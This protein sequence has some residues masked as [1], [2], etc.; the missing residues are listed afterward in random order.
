[1]YRHRGSIARQSRERQRGAK[2]RSA[3][4]QVLHTAVLHDALSR[5][6]A[7][8]VRAGRW[9]RRRYPLQIVLDGLQVPLAVLRSGFPVEWRCAEC[10]Q[11][12][13]QSQSATCPDARTSNV[14]GPRNACSGKAE[15]NGGLGTCCSDGSAEHGAS[16]AGA[17]GGHHAG[18]RL[19]CA[20]CVHRLNGLPLGSVLAS[21]TRRSRVLC[22]RD[23]RAH[24]LA[25]RARVHLR[26]GGRARG[27]AARQ[28][29]PA[30]GGAAGGHAELLAALRAVAAAAEAA[31]RPERGAQA[32]E[33]RRARACQHLA[34]RCN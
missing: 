17:H 4:G 26:R 5:G 16:V 3:A 28:K 31:R 9:R 18:R 20:H 32:R 11:A 24:A 23:V 14:T 21:A 7:R 33:Q 22:K 25:R 8:G 6:L 34:C 29:R 12:S 13:E 19:H 27:A 10:E 1:M 15:G 30:R 2:G